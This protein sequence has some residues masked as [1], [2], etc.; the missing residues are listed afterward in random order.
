[1]PTNSTKFG[2]F[3][4]TK[5]KYYRNKKT[6][7]ISQEKTPDS[8]LLNE[9]VYTIMGLNYTIDE[10]LKLRLWNDRLFISSKIG[11]GTMV[12]LRDQSGR[13]FTVAKSST[14]IPQ[15]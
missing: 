9:E 8:K 13:V 1:M 6:Q 5:M 7:V 3:L 11:D 2:K 10:A 14:T 15:L 4:L 12:N